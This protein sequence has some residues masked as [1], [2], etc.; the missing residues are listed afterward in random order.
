MKKLYSSLLILSLP[1]LLLAQ[2]P[3]GF[4]YQAIV[5]NSTGNPITDQTVGIQVSIIQTEATGTVVY[6]ERFSPTTNDYGLI[7][8]K[9]RNWRSTDWYIW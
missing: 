2:A 7:N 3:Q 1:F 6:V 9:I 4:N 8:I 5:R